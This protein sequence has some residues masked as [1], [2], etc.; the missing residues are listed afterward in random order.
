MDS[1]SIALNDN[2]AFGESPTFEQFQDRE[3]WLSGQRKA[4]SSALNDAPLRETLGI[5]V[6]TATSALGK[7]TRAAFFLTGPDGGTLHHIVGMPDD[8]ALA[9]DG[10]AVGP[11]SL[12]CGLAAHIGHAVRTADVYLDP[13]WEPWIWLADKYQ[14]RACWSYPIN[15]STGHFVG[16]FSLYWPEPR[17]AVSCD[18]ERA[19]LVTQAAGVIISRFKEAEERRK[20]EKS[21]LD[22]KKQ[23]EAELADS[24]LLRQISL[25]LAGDDGEDGLYQKL[26]SA[27]AQIMKSDVCTVQ[28]LHPERGP[29]GELEMLASTG[30]DAR[31]VEYWKWVRGDSGCTCGEVLRTGKRAIAEDVESCSFM[32]GTPDRDVLLGGGIRA[33]QTTPLITRDG[34]L[35]GMISTHWGEPHQPTERELRMLDIIARSAADLIERRRAAETQKLLLNELNHRVKNTLAVV[36]AMATRTLARSSDPKIFAKAFGG[37]VQSLAKI[38]DLLSAKSWEGADLKEL[39]LGQISAGLSDETRLAATGPA[40]RLDPQMALHLALIVHELGTNATKYGALSVPMGKVSIDW[41]IDEGLRIRWAELGGPRVEPSSSEGFGTTLIS[42][43]VRGLGG[44]AKMTALPEGIIWDITVPYT[45][46]TSG[47]KFPM[48][49]TKEKPA[50]AMEIHSLKGRRILVVEDEPLIGMDIV[51]ALEDAGAEVEGPVHSVE[52]AC[53]VIASGEFDAA[54]VDAN[55]HGKPVGPIA[56]AL[57]KRGVPFAFATG[58]DKDGLPDGFQDRPILGK[59]AGPEQVVAMVARLVSAH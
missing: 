33:G 10:L 59:P 31:G 30:L 44:E 21:L 52:E 49:K 4:F 32:A 58:Y 7:G 8:Y 3:V 2:L 55:L 15:T 16:T 53:A 34:K 43:S 57:T 38:H 45:V 26:V 56:A 20:A 51:A 1:K 35:V 5:L 41:R 46:K 19:A 25:E 12:A 13:L 27:A 42:Q 23:L 40:I 39:I 24:E 47:G 11:E 9:V 37:R 17:E 6:D 28:F 54:L 14:Y 48:A 18:I 29:A 22:T 50:Q 36:Q